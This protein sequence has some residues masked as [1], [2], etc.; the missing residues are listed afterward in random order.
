MCFVDSIVQKIPDA[1]EFEVN[2]IE[3]KSVSNLSESTYRELLEETKKDEVLHKLSE[4]IK[5]IPY[6]KTQVHHLVRSYWNCINEISEIDG[7]LFKG[8]RVI[9]PQSMQQYILKVIHQI[10]LGMVKC[11]QLA[12]DLVFWKGMNSQIEDVVSNCATC[13]QHRSCQQKEP[14]QN[15]EVPDSPWCDI[16]TDL[17]ECHGDTYLAVVDA[18]Y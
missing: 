15:R 16:A 17:F 14:L 13:Q 8:E 2:A 5:K 11:K 3:V 1:E 12:R 9:I 6:V 18:Y 4:V 10:H 7:I